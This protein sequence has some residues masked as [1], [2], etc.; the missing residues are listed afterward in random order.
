[1]RGAEFV[2]PAGDRYDRV[3]AIRQ[4]GIRRGGTAGGS[5]IRSKGARSLSR[6]ELEQLAQEFSDLSDG[7]RQEAEEWIEKLRPQLAKVLGP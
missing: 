6:S 5:A 1:M 7:D 2:T 4:G 3:V